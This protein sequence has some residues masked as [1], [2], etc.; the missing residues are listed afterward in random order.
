MYLTRKYTDQSLADIGQLYNL[1]EDPDETTNL[2][3]KPSGSNV[4]AMMR[5]RL[6]EALLMMRALPA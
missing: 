4:M 5:V 3:G 2:V 6:A 1:R